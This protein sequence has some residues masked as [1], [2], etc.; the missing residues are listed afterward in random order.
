MGAPTEEVCSVSKRFKA[1]DKFLTE[2]GGILTLEKSSHNSSLILRDAAGADWSKFVWPDSEGTLSLGEVRGMAHPV[3]ITGPLPKEIVSVGDQADSWVRGQ[4][5]EEERKTVGH[6]MDL[7][8]GRRGLKP[9]LHWVP[10]WALRGV[11]RVFDYGAQKYAPG[12]WIRAAQ[13]EDPTKALEDY[14]SAAERHWSEIQ[15]AD[16]WASIDEESGLP[17][18]DHLIC[19]LIMLRGIGQ[20]AGVLPS[21]PKEVARAA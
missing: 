18:V 20:K 12:N 15:E 10:L 8:I 13:E 7:K 9:P 11:A 17:H 3:E 16:D 21:D 2:G 6:L 19:S 5:A 14:L 4:E 1:G